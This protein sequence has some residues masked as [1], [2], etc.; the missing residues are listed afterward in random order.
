MDGQENNLRL[1]GGV[2]GV[3]V[4]GFFDGESMFSIETDASKVAL[5]NLLLRL[6]KN[7]FRL[8]DL[9]ILNSHTKSLGGVEIPRVEYMRRLA[10]ALSDP[11]VF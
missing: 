9:Q 1:V 4:N 11:V 3:A 5:F 2:Y 8:F 6:K 10:D 7:G